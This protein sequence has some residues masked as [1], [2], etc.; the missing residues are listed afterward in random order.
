MHLVEAGDTH[1]LLD[2]GLH[3][4]P[5]NLARE[6][7]TYPP[8]DPCALDAIV[9]SH[10]H[11]DHCGNIP[12]LVRQGFSGPI[13]CTPATRDLVAVML[14]DSARIQEEEAAVARTID[15]ADDVYGQPLYTQRDVDQA[16]RQ[17]VTVEYNTPA[18]LPGDVQLMLRDAGHLLGSATIALSLRHADR[19][20]TIAFTGDLGRPGLPFL[21]PPAPLPAADLLLC[22]ST[23]GGRTHQPLDEL[24]AALAAVVTRTL[25]RGGKVLIPAFSLGRAQVVV[26]YLQEWMAHGRMP[27][28]PLYV[29]SGLAA[30]IAE[31]YRLHPDHLAPNTLHH[32]AEAPEGTVH[33]ARSLAES[34]EL[35]QRPEPCVLVASGGMCEAGRILRHLTQHV[36]DPRCSI[37]L[38]SYQAPQSLGHRLRERGPTVRFQG[39]TWNKWADV[40]DLNGFSGHADHN[41][42]LAQLRPL[43]GK[44]RVRLVH[45]DLE[46][47]SLLAADLR[48]HGFEDVGIPARGE[49]VVLVA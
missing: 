31:L 9:L 28:A 16:I 44:T 48:G 19:D 36:D 47:A 11:I 3:L 10:A 14:A 2:C 25:G 23:Y 35:S 39:K 37:V 12:N 49:S 13:Y 29:D 15:I 33:Y 6:R 46:H 8:F 40:V 22:E 27:Q 42:L 24:A 5:R 41:D 17:C 20:R 45:G 32:L 43:A 4:G 7:N 21:H 26:Y 1:I 34:K 38:V 30:S 18:L